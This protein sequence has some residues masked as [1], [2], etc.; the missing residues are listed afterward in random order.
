MQV[1]AA[2]VNGIDFMLTHIDERV[3]VAGDVVFIGINSPPQYKVGL[4]KSGNLVQQA[5]VVAP[6]T[7]FYFEIPTVDDV[8]SYV[9]LDC[10]LLFCFI[11]PLRSL[12]IYVVID[13]WIN[14]NICP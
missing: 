12:S 10:S 11:F 8:V 14:D 1:N 4:Y 2:D 5:V 9:L 3:D 7:V 13:Q 6:S